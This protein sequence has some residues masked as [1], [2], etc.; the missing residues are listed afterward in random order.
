MKLRTNVKTRI[1][2]PRFN[3]WFSYEKHCLLFLDIVTAR[4]VWFRVLPEYLTL[5]NMTLFNVIYT[6]DYVCMCVYV[7]IYVWII[8]CIYTYIYGILCMRARD[9]CPRSPWNFY[10]CTQLK[11]DVILKRYTV[12]PTSYITTLYSQHTPYIKYTH[13]YSIMP[14]QFV[15]SIYFSLIRQFMVCSH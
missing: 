10:T 3:S 14:F 7:C 8:C 11:I 1:S 5:K 6:R 13:R 12:V 9:N 2:Q 4:V 15:L